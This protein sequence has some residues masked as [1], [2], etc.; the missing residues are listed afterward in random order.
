MNLPIVDPD[1]RTEEKVAVECWYPASVDHSK[2]FHWSYAVGNAS[3]SQNL[4]LILSRP[5]SLLRIGER[6]VPAA[7]LVEVDLFD[8]IPLFTVGSETGQLHS[9][10]LVSSDLRLGTGGERSIVRDGRDAG[11]L[12]IL[13]PIRDLL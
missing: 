3:V 9:R 13:A 1:S 10:P 4:G 11:L 2:S 8:L 12:A 7:P 5:E 6:S